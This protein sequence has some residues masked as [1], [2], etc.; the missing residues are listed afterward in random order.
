[1]FVLRGFCQKEG[2]L[3]HREP[4]C[5]D[6]QWRLNPCHV[7]HGEDTCDI[8]WEEPGPFSDGDI[9]RLTSE[10]N[11]D[12]GCNVFPG[13]TPGAFNPRLVIFVDYP[14]VT[15]E[16]ILAKIRSRVLR[17]LR[18]E[19]TEELI[20]ISRQRFTMQRTFN[21]QEKFRHLVDQWRFADPTFAPLIEFRDE[22]RFWVR[23]YE[24]PFIGM[25]PAFRGVI[26]V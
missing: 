26:N 15:K 13:G 1:M 18:G 17:H 19:R 9:D 21:I 12:G 24:S 6:Y 3:A 4:I 25:L 10:F 16:M 7:C 8:H 20:F 2:N 11:Y 5:S 14:G 22:N 23:E